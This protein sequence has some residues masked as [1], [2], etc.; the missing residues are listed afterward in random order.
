[1]TAPRYIVQFRNGTWQVFDTIH[2]GVVRSAA[3][4]KRAAS[5]AEYLNA[6]PARKA[7]RR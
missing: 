1:M 7:V 2:Y 6:R 4:F 3:L 5:D